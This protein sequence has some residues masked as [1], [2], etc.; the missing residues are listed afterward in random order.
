MHIPDGFLEPKVWICGWGLSAAAVATCLKKINRKLKDNTVPLMG[1]MAAFIFAAQMVNFPVL[2]GTSGHL[3]GGVLAA[4]LLG[5]YAGVVVIAL[6]L[7]VQCLFFQD[8]GLT[9]LGANI[10]NMAIVGTFGG[11][12]V[13]D[14]LRKVIKGDN[15][16]LIATGVAAWAS[17]V[18]SA[19]FCALELAVS[20]AAPLKVVLP[21]MGFVHT[22]IA[23]AEALITTLIVSFILRVRA[24]LIYK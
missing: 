13:Y 8:G 22:F 10:F 7:G 6:V 21:A 15:G 12:I 19:V 9:A 20:G 2:A 16:V 24:D 17:V 3:L 5:P 4:V 18:S 23:T 11:Y 1:V 14:I